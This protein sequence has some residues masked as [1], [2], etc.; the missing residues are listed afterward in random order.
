MSAPLPWPVGALRDRLRTLAAAV[1]D[2]RDHVIAGREEARQRFEAIEAAIERLQEA[3]AALP[4]SPEPVDQARLMEAIRVVADDEPATRA[5]LW[6]LRDTEEYVAAYEEDEP[7]VSVVIPTYHN[8]EL[9]RDRSLPSVLAQTY[10]RL[11]VIV[12]GDAAPD[13]ACEAVES[14][15]DPRVFFHNLPLRGPYPDDVSRRWHVSGVPPYNE[16]VRLATGRWIAPQDDDDAWH[17]DHVERLLG[18]ARE[19]RAELAYGRLR[20]C[21]PDGPQGSVGTFPPVQ[22]EFGMQGSLYHSG[23]ARIFECELSDDVWGVPTDWAWCRRMLRAGVRVAMLDA[24][25]VDYY[26]SRGS[27]E[28]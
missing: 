7:L 16:G 11:E 18:L 9:L 8:H 12:V 25:V 6:A 3:V 21:G 2:T 20:V 15:G 28:G 10:S 4:P 19:R 26:P 17:P 5:A 24:D 27:D 1:G 23:L 14:F 13:A 22:G